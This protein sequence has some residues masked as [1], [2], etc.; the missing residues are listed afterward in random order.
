[1]GFERGRGDPALEHAF[2]SSAKELV[3][4]GAVA[5][6]TNCGFAIRHQRAI[7]QAVSVPV[8]TS[9]LLIVPLVATLTS[10]TLGLVTFDTRPLTGDLLRMAGIDAHD[11]SVVVAGLEGTRSWEIMSQPDAPITVAQLEEDLLVVVESLQRRHGGVSALVFE[12]AGF[13]VASK[14]VRQATGLP[15]Y[16]VTNLANLLMSGVWRGSA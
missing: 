6:T 9:A 11:A 2:V 14:R 7:A 3:G 1:V 5:L 10:G 15:V 12:C 4:R 8:A 16:D 13:P